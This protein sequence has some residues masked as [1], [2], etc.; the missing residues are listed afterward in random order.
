MNILIHEAPLSVSE[1][2]ESVLLQSLSKSNEQAINEQFVL[3]AMSDNN[4]MLGGLTA[5]T[6]YGWLLIK[7]LWVDD[8]HRNKGLGKRLM[9][10][11]ESK[12]RSMQCHASWLDTSSPAA[13]AFYETLGYTEFGVLQ[14]SAEHT[15]ALH[16][17]WFMNKTL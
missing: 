5:S 8:K 1:Q 6:S 13:R 3:Q 2:I 14:N 17:R 15:P 11:A 7:T 10:Q 9:T 16:K 4:E 12:G